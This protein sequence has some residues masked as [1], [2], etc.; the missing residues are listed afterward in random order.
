LD[1]CAICAGGRKKAAPMVVRTFLVLLLQKT[2]NNQFEN[3]RST[4]ALPNDHQGGAE[5][6]GMCSHQEAQ[7]IFDH[8]T[9]LIG[10]LEPVE[11]TDTD[12]AQPA[13]TNFL[14]NFVPCL[15]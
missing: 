4:L 1:R 10:I 9:N 14:W 3:Y 7:G 12:T 5:V 11:D 15:I 2:D 13:G 8:D 6:T